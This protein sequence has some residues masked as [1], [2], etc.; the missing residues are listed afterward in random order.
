MDKSRKE[1]ALFHDLLYYRVYC[2]KIEREFKTACFGS[3]LVFFV[4]DFFLKFIRQR[5]NG[6][7]HSFVFFV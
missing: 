1:L 6:F 3:V 7:L 5:I 2:D 4:H